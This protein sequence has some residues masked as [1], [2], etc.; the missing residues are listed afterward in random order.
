M[1]LG[2]MLIRD[3]LAPQRNSRGVESGEW[4]VANL[5]GCGL[6]IFDTSSHL[7]SL[8]VALPKTIAVS[9]KSPKN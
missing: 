2:G 1:G 4:L 9:G 7:P 8:R 6:F 3:E 5:A